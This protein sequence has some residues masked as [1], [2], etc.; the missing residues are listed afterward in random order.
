MINECIRSTRKFGAVGIIG[1]YVGVTNHFNVG[2]LMERG[3]RLIGCGQAPVQKYWED[4]LYKVENLTIDPTIMLTHRFKI[5]DIAK[6]YYVQEKREKGLV[7]CFVETRFSARPA[8][9]TPELTTL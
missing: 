3:I 6:G 9:D 5:D 1:D 7:K 2:S 4:L 8:P